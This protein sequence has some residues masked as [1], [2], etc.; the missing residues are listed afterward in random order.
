MAQQQQQTNGVDVERLAATIDAVKQDPQAAAFVFRGHTKWQGGARS[1]TRF[2]AFHGAGKEDSSRST[3]LVMQGDEPSVLLGDD[4]APNAVEAVLHA[5][6]S[7]LTV[8]LVYNAA[9]K[10]IQ[11]RGLEFDVEGELD[12]HRFLGLDPD[13]RPGYRRISVSCKVDAD[14]PR[15]ELERLVQYVQETSPVLDVLENPVD[16][17]IRIM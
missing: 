3:D 15:E 14:A 2:K 13:K 6:T 1:E 9:A 4:T 12:L 8:G 17:Q 10:G 7:C 16:V 11:V 5:L